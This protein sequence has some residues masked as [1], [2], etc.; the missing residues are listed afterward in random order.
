MIN[1]VST[2][3]ALSAILVACVEADADR[4][5]YAGEDV[6]YIVAT[7]A[8]GGYDAYA[9]HIGTYLQKYLQVDN[10]VIRNVPGAGHIVGANTLWRARPNGLTIGTFNAG[11]IYEQ[12]LGDDALRL[13]LRK[14]QWIG[15][16]AGEPRAIVVSKSCPIKSVEDLMAAT[17]PVKFGSAGI[18]SA[19]YSDTMLLAAAL[20]LKVQVIPGFD[21]TEGE[22]SML[23]GEICAV[24]GSASSFINFINAGHG[25]YLLAIGDGLAGVP[26]AIDYATTDRGRR[27]LKF[28]DSL[29]RLGRVTAAPPG[30]PPERVAALRAAYKA[31]LEDPQF[32]AESEK[33]GQPIEPAYGE[34][35]Q[36]LVSEAL[37][38]TPQTIE[39]IAQAING[40]S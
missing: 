29:S 13:D 33:L 5:F 27:L 3:L 24:L 40:G 16:A 21:G 8:G 2:L 1:K 11:L 38:Q 7:A 25:S 30:T 15:K 20:D 34:D 31:S 17:T 39:L 10:V 23:R 26:N 36:Q 37:D 28:I 9:R 4:D 6:T 19:S 32:L 18:G 22:M 35:V 14:F 12:L